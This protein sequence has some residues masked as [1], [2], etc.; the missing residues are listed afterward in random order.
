MILDIALKDLQLHN[1]HNSLEQEKVSVAVV[2]MYCI[3]V[4]GVQCVGKPG[5]GV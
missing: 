1:L 2:L 5:A 3:Y 4:S